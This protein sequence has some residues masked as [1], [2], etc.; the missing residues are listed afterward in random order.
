VLASWAAFNW[1]DGSEFVDELRVE[2][3]LPQ[4]TSPRPTV[5]S[6]D[7]TAIEA[8]ARWGW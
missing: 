1:P 4:A 8:R 5:A 2:S 3:S 6:V 7:A